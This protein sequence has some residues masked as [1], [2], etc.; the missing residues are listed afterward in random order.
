MAAPGARSEA[1]AQ[2]LTRYWTG[3]PCPQGHV[4]ER[5]VSNGRCVVCMKAITKAKRPQYRERHREQMD[6]YQRAYYQENRERVLLR[7]RQYHAANRLQRA[8]SIRAYREA[9]PV[10]WRAHVN[11]ASNRRRDRKQHP[12][13]PTQR[14][15]VSA[16][17]RAAQWL[18][19]STGT[20]YEVHHQVP[21]AQGGT[22]T[23]DS[24]WILTQA[25]HRAIH[26]VS[27]P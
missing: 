14:R 24:L 17:Y 13:T 8:A 27:T 11:N 5:M 15:Q 10:W 18:S 25:A 4:A 26:S 19:A 21:I 22:H 1:R 6:E 2:G 3:N 20:P 16:I 7:C 23:P 12:L 9:N